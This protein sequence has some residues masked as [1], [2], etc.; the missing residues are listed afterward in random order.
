MINYKFN[1]HISEKLK[2]KR[3]QNISVREIKDACLISGQL[4]I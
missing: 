2:E 3:F 4:F 1:L